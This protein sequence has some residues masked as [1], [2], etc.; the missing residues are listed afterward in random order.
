MF[1][2][3]PYPYSESQKKSVEVTDI[4]S[5][6][7]EQ[8]EE[9][10]YKA[11]MARYKYVGALAQHTSDLYSPPPELVEGVN[12]DWN[13]LDDRH[14]V[15]LVFRSHRYPADEC[16]LVMPKDP[17]SIQKCDHQRRSDPTAARTYANLR[18]TFVRER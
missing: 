7:K 17:T 9:M 8:Q 15:Y 3:Q 2:W 6:P 1:N 16:E 5:L 14:C 4:A 13:Y 12:I 18:R 10:R 11:N